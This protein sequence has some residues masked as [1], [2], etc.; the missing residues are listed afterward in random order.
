M[1]HGLFIASLISTVVQGVKDAFTPTI[2]A[3]NWDNKELYYQDLANGMSVDQCVKNA[4]NGK[5]KLV[6]RYPEPHRDPKTGQIVIENCLLYNED[7]V[8]YGTLQAHEW[9]KQGRY[10]LTPE[11][12]KKEEERIRKHHEF[13]YSLM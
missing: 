10:N 2:P 12:L 6:G 13:L 4:K 8:K 3:E 9:A 1:L 11:E 7:K 5:Y